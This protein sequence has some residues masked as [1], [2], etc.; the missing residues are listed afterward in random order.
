ML[1]F[2][3]FFVT[4][5]I[6]Q[7]KFMQS[8]LP[9]CNASTITINQIFSSNSVTNYT[10]YA[11]SLMLCG[12]NT[13]VYDTLYNSITQ[14]IRNYVFIGGNSRYV[15]KGIDDMWL[16]TIYIKSTAT[17]ELMP[18]ATQNSLLVLLVE[19]GATVINNSGFN[20]YD[21]DTCS[22]LIFPEGC[23]Y[24]NLSENSDNVKGAIKI[25]PSPADNLLQLQYA[26][27]IEEPDPEVLVYNNLGQ[28]V[29]QER[30]VFENKKATI[31][32]TRLA[33][34]IYFLEL[35]TTSVTYTR[36]RFVID[37]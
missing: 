32:I 26:L 1:N 33:N 16:T 6:L 11:S 4:I 10:S 29:Q 30:I 23:N 13:V 18:T 36:M 35:K 22:S 20:F 31:P 5:L 27:D 8:Q 34:G 28:L 2:R 19:P 21:I 9:L 14:P 24:V 12:P 17:L 25:W 37:R 7:G 15:G 3:L